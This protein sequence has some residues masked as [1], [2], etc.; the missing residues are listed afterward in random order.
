MVSFTIEISLWFPNHSAVTGSEASLIVSGDRSSALL[1]GT[2]LV[3]LKQ[4]GLGGYFAR[5]LLGTV[6][7]R[8]V[9]F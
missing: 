4:P 1:E 9:S 6:T 8:K 5:D 3:A 7:L 2:S